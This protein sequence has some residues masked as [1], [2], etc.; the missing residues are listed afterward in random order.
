MKMTSS[1]SGGNGLINAPEFALC[2][3]A[4]NRA[5]EGV[6]GKSAIVRLVRVVVMVAEYEG[7][8]WAFNGRSRKGCWKWESVDRQIGSTIQTPP[9]FKV[10]GRVLHGLPVTVS[11]ALI[12]FR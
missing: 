7:S 3:G 1:K 6:V 5:G 12:G 11:T 4:L 2:A 10:Q 8:T 9:S